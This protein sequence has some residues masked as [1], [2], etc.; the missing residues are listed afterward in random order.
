MKIAII[1]YSGSGKSTLAQKLAEHYGIKALHLDSVHFLPGWVEKDLADE[2]RE[3]EAYLDANDSWVIDGNYTKLSYERRLREADMII[4]ML[5]NR[6]ACLKRVTMR[7]LRFRNSSRPD[8]GEGCNEKLD[9]EFIS[10]VLW[11]SRKKGPRSRYRAT[12]E[13]YAGK[14]TVVKN[15]KQLDAL[16]IKLEEEQRHKA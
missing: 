10:W 2:Q 7:Y 13:R 16:Y 4:M 6:F 15:Q 11:R 9:A 8:M 14:V 3:V 1:G 5:F 12:R